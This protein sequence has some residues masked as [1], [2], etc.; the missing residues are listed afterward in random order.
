MSTISRGFTITALLM[1]FAFSQA[2]MAQLEKV[3]PVVPVPAG[4]GTHP[5]ENGYPIWYE[6]SNGLILELCLDQNGLCLLELP[7]PGNP[8]TFPNNF[9]GEGFWFNAGASMTMASGGDAE[10][11][12]AL[13]GAFLNEEVIDG[14]QISFGRVRIR[15]DTPIAGG[16]F[17]VTHPYGVDVFEVP[18]G[19]GGIRAVNFTEDIGIGQPGDFTGALISRIGPFL[20]WDSSAPSPPAGYIGDPLT[21]HAVTGSPLGTNFF[22]VEGPGVGF[23]PALACSNSDVTDCAEI[24]LFSVSGKIATNFGAAI[25]SATYKRSTTGDG[26]ATIFASSQP[27]QSIQLSGVGAGPVLMSEAGTSGNYMANVNF[28]SSNFGGGTIT[29]ANQGDTAPTAVSRPLS[30]RVKVTSELFS[31]VTGLMGI[32]AFSS[33]RFVPPTLTVN[34]FGDMTGGNLSVPVGVP[35]SEI[36]VTSSAGGSDSAV[37]KVVDTAAS[38]CAGEFDFDGDIDGDDLANFTGDYGRTDCPDRL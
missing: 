35:P 10:L 33:D 5:I 36:T 37:V 1:V 25:T 27:A 14:D 20:V 30:D 16:T 8:I 31:T 3:G 18:A 12:L 9:T 29:L 28:N 38:V 26:K 17:T 34:G 13:E 4:G 7:N 2:A 21:P 24:D 11:G 22:R 23:D 15:I 19:A 32:T 6:D